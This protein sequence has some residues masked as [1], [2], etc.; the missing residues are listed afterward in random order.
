MNK[1]FIKLSLLFFCVGLLFVAVGVRADGMFRNTNYHLALESD[2]LTNKQG[3]ILPKD[4]PIKD[5]YGNV[6][7]YVTHK[8]YKNLKL[9]GSGKLVDGRVLNYAGRVN[10]EVRFHFTMHPWGR[11]AGNCPL[12]PWKTLAV[13]PSQIPL[14]STVMVAETKGM[15]LPDGSIHDGIWYAKD[16]G[17]AILKDRIDLFIANIRDRKYLTAHGITHLKPL[18]V[19][20][21]ELPAN[22]SCIYKK[23]Q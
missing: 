20:V 14:G 1:D 21:L 2:D 17:G 9:E 23:P 4:T 16:T 8:F 22:D 15:R 12:I 13:D 7:V 5:K 18:R 11:A 10:G 19:T 6:L 3:E